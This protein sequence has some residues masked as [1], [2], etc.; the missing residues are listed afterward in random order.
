MVAGMLIWI[1]LYVAFFFKP[2]YSGNF[3]KK[4]LNIILETFFKFATST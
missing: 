1:G 2:C 4:I 3:N